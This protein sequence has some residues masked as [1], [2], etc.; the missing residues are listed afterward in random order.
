MADEPAKKLPAPTGGD[1][2]HTA[3]K[4]ALSVVPYLGGPASEL[5]G[6][7]IAP[8][9]TK[10]R[11]EWMAEIAGG[12]AALKA[13]VARLDIVAL[14]KND[15]FITTVMH[16][17]ASAVKNHQREKLDALRNAVLNST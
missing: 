3:A 8:P 6:A 10:R 13:K 11:D 2:A 4:A 1:W 9:L 12:L 7:V 5:F 17:S 14:S 16:A 15:V